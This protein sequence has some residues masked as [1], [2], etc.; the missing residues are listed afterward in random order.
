MQDLKLLAL[1]LPEDG[2]SNVQFPQH[3][4]N[5]CTGPSYPTEGLVTQLRVGL[6]PCSTPHPL[7]APL[8]S[9]TSEVAL[10]FRLLRR[11]G[12]RCRSYPSKPYEPPQ[13]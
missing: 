9:P 6:S 2:T 4:N 3:L 12:L 10:Q 8:V 7:P 13:Q 5:S 11:K 1:A